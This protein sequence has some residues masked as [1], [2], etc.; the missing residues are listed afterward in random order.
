MRRGNNVG[1]L[2]IKIFS[3]GVFAAF[4]LLFLPSCRN[5]MQPSHVPEDDP[6]VG[7]LSLTIDGQATE[8][9]IMPGEVPSDFVKFELR[10]NAMSHLSDNPAENTREITWDMS[11]NDN[12]IVANPDGTVTGTVDDLRPRLW[13]LRVF[14]YVNNG[15]G[16][17]VRVAAANSSNIMVF[18]GQTVGGR[19]QLAMIADGLGEGTFSWDMGFTTNTDPARRVDTARMEFVRLPCETPHDKGPFYFRG[20]AVGTIPVGYEGTLSL[21][22]GRYRVVFTLVNGDGET[23]VATEILHVYQNMVSHFDGNSFADFIFPIE[24][25]RLILGAW[26]GVAGTWNFDGTG[27]VAGHFPILGVQGVA[28]L[29]AMVG[30]FNELSVPGTDYIAGGLERLKILV[31]AALVGIASESEAFRY[32]GKKDRQALEN[33]IAGLARN[34]TAMTFVEWDDLT[35]NVSVGGYY[36]LTIT[37]FTRPVTSVTIAPPGPLE[38]REGEKKNLTATVLP[39]NATDRA[40]TWTSSDPSVATVGTGGLVTAV[41]EGEAYVTATAVGDVTSSPVMVRVTMIPPTGGATF[42]V[43]LAPGHQMQPI[44]GPSIRQGEQATFTVSNPGDYAD[45]RWFLNGNRVTVPVMISGVN[46]G[47][48]TVGPG[49]HGDQVM[50]HFITVEA[51]RN[52][53]P[54]GQI[55]AFEILPASGT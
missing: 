19:V 40:I 43:R 16:D 23:A 18:P 52:G 37:F 2:A 15:D 5:P 46:G 50:M 6:N 13:N 48:L 27:I 38:L 30:M 31:D 49:I 54:Y 32:A 33:A 14:A 55:V 24:L 17:P 12:G 8:R 51:T 20:G 39:S 3:A 26:D 42:T 25:L 47:T 53:V 22:S 45:I 44:P 7:R 1:S 29:A 41:A 36:G 10:L 21:P 4:V 9:T 35:V 28:N 34:N 11:G